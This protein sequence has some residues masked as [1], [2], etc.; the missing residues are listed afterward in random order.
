[1]LIQYQI[2]IIQATIIWVQVLLD[3][4]CRKREC[5]LGNVIADSMVHAYTVNYKGSGWSDA[6]I[7]LISG[8]GIRST[9]DAKTSGGNVTME[10]LMTVL[11]F[12][13]DL[14]VAQY[15]GSTI[16]KAFEHSVHR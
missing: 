8:G 2:P 15:K 6:S 14:I 10:E 12:G 5:N 9:I 3:G 4:N 7:A 1:M 11:P 16:K 13:N